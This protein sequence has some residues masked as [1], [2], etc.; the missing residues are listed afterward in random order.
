MLDAKELIQNIKNI[1]DIIKEE[2]RT[3]LLAGIPDN[4]NINRLGAG[5][6]TM[7]VSAL[8]PDLALSPRYYDFLSQRDLLI[9]IIEKKP[10]E[11][12]SKDFHT[13]ADTS[14][15]KDERFHPKVVENLK[16]IMQKYNI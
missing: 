5:C 15:L 12:W 2:M 10:I 16:G 13:I 4:P 7:K 1:N 8:S 6:F 11:Q 3:A 14:R 9:G